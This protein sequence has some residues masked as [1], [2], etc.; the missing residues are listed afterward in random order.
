MTEPTPSNG[1]G[2]NAP[3]PARTEADLLAEHHPMET[4]VGYILQVGVV[5]SIA[6]LTV[7]L[8]W[9]WLTTGHF[10]IEYSIR[11]VNLFQFVVQDLRL[12]AERAFRPRLFVSLGIAVLLLTPYIRV[13]ASMVLFAVV[14][15]NAKYTAFTGFVLLVLTYTLFLR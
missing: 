8:G 11:G 12:T 6:L 15:R 1:R 14:E 2:P 3:A 13:L 9:R 7:G 5:L 4:V 10:A